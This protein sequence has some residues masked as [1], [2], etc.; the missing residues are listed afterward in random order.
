MGLDVRDVLHTGLD[1]LRHEQSFFLSGLQ[2]GEALAQA[3]A[4]R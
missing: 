1:L 4:V 3:F 2:R